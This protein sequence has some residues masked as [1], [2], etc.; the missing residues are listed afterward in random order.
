MIL[1]GQFRDVKNKL[2]TLTINNQNGIEE[3]VVIGNRGLQFAGSPVTIESNVDDSFTH[4]IR[5][6]AT[7]NLVTD[8][9]IGD[10]LFAN[11]SRNISVRI[12]DDSKTI[13]QGY[14]EPSTFNQ[15]FVNSIDE[16]SINCTDSLSTL[17]YFN[18]KKTTVKNYDDLKQTAEITSFRQILD[19]LFQQLG[20]K[21]YYDL[22]KA[23]KKGRE[24]SV[25]EDLSI[26]ETYLF[27]DDFDDIWTEEEV[28]EQMLQYLNLHII[29]EGN[30]Y[31][32]FDWESIRN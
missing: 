17:Q 24:K 27:G 4:I 26:S 13:F 22:S 23:V 3:T 10:K 18:Y 16:F 1:T 25:F 11:N 30:D 21:F 6:N 19:D 15:P 29:Q 14:V 2:Y 28:L 32:I 8:K 31:Y 20:G 7:I 9:Y 5:K 12:D